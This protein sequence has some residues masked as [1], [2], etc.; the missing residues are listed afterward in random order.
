MNIFYLDESPE[1]AAGYLHDKHVVKMCLETAQILSTVAAGKALGEL[2]RT[3]RPTHAGHP[4]VK[5]VAASYA[6]WDWL[7]RHGLA[8]G[9]EYSKRWH[10]KVHASEAVISGLAKWGEENSLLW[11]EW[12]RTP[13]A[14]AMPEGYRREDPVE[15]YRVYYKREKVGQSRW[16]RRERPDWLAEAE[17]EGREGK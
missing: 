16:T 11:S 1:R 13:P 15:A 14:Q 12:G 10:G 17:A 6:N 5:W 2:P 3:Y 9:K 7:A 4:C 8:I